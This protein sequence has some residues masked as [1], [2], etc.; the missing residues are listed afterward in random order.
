MSASGR[1]IVAVLKDAGGYIPYHDR[2]APA[3][4][5]KT[6]ALSKKEIKPNE[7]QLKKKLGDPGKQCC[8]QYQGNNPE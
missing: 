4:I 1:K 8:S 6:F 2:S 5:K 3:Q 7:I